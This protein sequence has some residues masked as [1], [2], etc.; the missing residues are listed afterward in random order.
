M[1]WADLDELSHVN[2]VVYLDYASEARA[3]HVAAGELADRSARSISVEFLRPLLLSRRPVVV[4][5]VDDGTELV[6]VIR[7]AG[8]SGVFARVTWS[9]SADPQAP[10]A[11]GGHSHDIRMRLSDLGPDGTA[12]VRSLFEVV[13]EARVAS[14]GA[15][16]AAA[17]NGTTQRF[18]VAR[19]DL[20]L[21][22]PVPWRREPYAGRSVVTRV[23]RSSF[24]VSTLL[25]EGRLGSA[26]A[27]M[28]GFD[29]TTQRSRV[30]EDAEL[31]VL[32]AQLSPR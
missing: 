17:S 32:S 29:L 19:I 21:G 9:G 5:S 10:V 22:E 28:V 24:T 3:V 1:R 31:A 4:E 12:S 13:Q 26:E 18:V 2:N 15:L 23:G 14:L 25:E 27:V 7:P 16:R 8:S 20:H 11:A 30:L 6:Q